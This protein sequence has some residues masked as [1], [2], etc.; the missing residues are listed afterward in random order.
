MSKRDSN[1]KQS[2][3]HDGH[4]KNRQ[5]LLKWMDQLE[6]GRQAQAKIL[7]WMEEIKRGQQAQL[8]ILRH[9]LERDGVFHEATGTCG[10][11]IRSAV[12]EDVRG[13]VLEIV[14]SIHMFAVTP[15]KEPNASTT[16][17]RVDLP[18]CTAYDSSNTLMTSHSM[19]DAIPQSPADS[20]PVASN[21]NSAKLDSREGKTLSKRTSL[22]KLTTNLASLTT[23][24]A[25]RVVQKS[26]SE[27]SLHPIDERRSNVDSKYVRRKSVETPE[28]YRRGEWSPQGEITPHLNLLEE[29]QYQ[30]EDF[31]CPQNFQIMSVKC[32]SLCSQPGRPKKQTVWIK[33]NTMR[34]NDS[35]CGGEALHDQ[36]VS[37]PVI[38]Q[39]M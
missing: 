4:K 23:G 5:Q 8:E 13:Q 25:G 21:N 1:C 22:R 30:V 28:R 19:D 12:D 33:M 11:A 2:E 34:G 29:K 38:E 15:N 10:C 27:R 6:R 39:I 37:I 35:N 16:R 36:I 26:N 14:P 17:L 9:L 24:H 31:F 7:T 20:I 18:R 3:P 32:D